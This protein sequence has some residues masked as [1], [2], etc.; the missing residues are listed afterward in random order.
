LE[1]AAKS[2]VVVVQCSRASGRVAPRRRLRESGIVA[3][4]DFTSQKARIL[5]M[6]ALLATDD[7]IEVQRAFQTY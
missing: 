1:S 6:L 2:G 5:L 7:V 4:E 3:G